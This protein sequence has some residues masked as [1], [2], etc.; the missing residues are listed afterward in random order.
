MRFS[1]GNYGSFNH[2]QPNTSQGQDD[3]MRGSH[4][5]LPVRVE[6]MLLPVFPQCVPECV[7]NF[8]ELRHLKRPISPC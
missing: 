5:L 4:L 7:L 2:S 1:S 8:M 6:E 3:F